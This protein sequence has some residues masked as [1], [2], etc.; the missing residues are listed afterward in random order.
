MDA[1][2][3]D[4]FLEDFL[5]GGFGDLVV[6]IVCNVCRRVRTILFAE[7]RENEIAGY[8]THVNQPPRTDAE[9]KDV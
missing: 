2:C 6:E 7:V 3:I 4:E 1:S 8:S 9:I 5:S